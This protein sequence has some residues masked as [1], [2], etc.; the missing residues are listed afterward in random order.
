MSPTAGH[1]KSFPYHFRTNG[2]SPGFFCGLS[3]SSPLGQNLRKPHA[4][5]LCVYY[6]NSMGSIHAPFAQ[7]GRAAIP[8]RASS[9]YPTIRGARQTQSDSSPLCPT[10]QL[11]PIKP[12]SLNW[13]KRASTSHCFPTMM[14]N[15]YC[16]SL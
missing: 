2:M 7:T 16:K 15:L 14:E 13:Q 6:I 4:C 5:S 9:P 8:N 12:L 3:P 10:L 1:L 11:L